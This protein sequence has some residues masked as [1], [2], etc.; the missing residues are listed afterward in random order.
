MEWEG[1]KLSVSD[2]EVGKGCCFFCVELSNSPFLLSFRSLERGRGEGVWFRIPRAT[3]VERE[4][5]GRLG[6]ARRSGAGAAARLRWAGGVA[7]LQVALPTANWTRT[8]RGSAALPLCYYSRPSCCRPRSRKSTRQHVVRSAIAS[9]DQSYNRDSPVSSEYWIEMLNRYDEFVLLTINCMSSVGCWA[10]SMCSLGEAASKQHD[11]TI[12]L[13]C[14]R[15]TAASDRLHRRSDWAHK[16]LVDC[17]RWFRR[18]TMGPWYVANAIQQFNS[19]VTG[20]GCRE[21][22][23]A[24]STCTTFAFHRQTGT[25]RRSLRRRLIFR[26]RHRKGSDAFVSSPIVLFSVREP[27]P[28]TGF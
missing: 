5:H 22:H 4:R 25:A 23:V 24:C 8:T 17:E 28:S 9:N 7:N 21:I 12:S 11:S 6:S 2:F 1:K 27:P 13:E 10:C 15:R 20:L 14:V 19:E 16:L 26:H 3:F 18:E